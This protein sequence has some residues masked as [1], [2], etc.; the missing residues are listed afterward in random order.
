MKINRYPK[1]KPTRLKNYN[2]SQPGYY[3]VTICTYNH[4]LLFGQ[5]SKPV[6][7]QR[8]VPVTIHNKIPE[9]KPEININQY[10]KIA[11]W[12]KTIPTNK[13]F[14]D[15]MRKIVENYY[16]N[17]YYYNDNGNWAELSTNIE[18]DRVYKCDYDVRLFPDKI[19]YLWA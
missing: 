14:C 1:R 2:Y 13:S 10:G 3:Y 6:G 12:H 19:G 15:V 11:Q 9:S 8:A 18:G 17:Y 4:N 7:A 16:Q 5:I